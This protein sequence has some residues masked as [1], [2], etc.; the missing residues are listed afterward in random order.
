MNSRILKHG[1]DWTLFL[2]RDG[3]INRRIV[4]GYITDWDEFEFL[5]GTFEAIRKLSACF[6]RIVVVSNQQGVGK[7]LMT[8]QDVERIHSSMTREI[9]GEG[10]R[11]DLVLYAPY[12]QSEGSEMRKPSTGMALEAHRVFPEISFEKSVMA[13]DSIT[14]MQ[15]GR[16]AGM[17]TVLVCEDESLALKNSELLDFWYPNL[18]TFSRN[19]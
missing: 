10:G 1:K 11:I 17:V 4:D 16:N 6:G 13:G 5:P 19:L 2:D 8:A 3:V 9:E 15:F 18:L 7:G 12:L 14:D